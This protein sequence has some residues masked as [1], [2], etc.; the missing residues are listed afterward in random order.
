MEE[1]AE[2]GWE[3]R[4]VI[5]LRGGAIGDPGLTLQRMDSSSEDEGTDA[6]GPNSER[7]PGSVNS[8]SLACYASS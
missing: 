1:D 6:S 8:V 3:T 4:G 5:R 2:G 7:A